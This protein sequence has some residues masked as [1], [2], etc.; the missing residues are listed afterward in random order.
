MEF[1]MADN[2]LKKYLDLVG[3]SYLK[4]K[5]IECLKEYTDAKTS[6]LILRYQSI[7]EFPIIGDESKLYISTSTNS[8]YRWDDT[9]IKYYCIGSDYNNIEVING[10]SSS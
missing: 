10:G 1:C 6:E 8:L 5:I 9:S 2:N 7:H 4:D 3:A